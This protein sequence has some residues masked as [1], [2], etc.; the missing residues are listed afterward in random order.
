MPNNPCAD[1]Q[2]P[3]SASQAKACRKPRDMRRWHEGGQQY[4][5]WQ[6]RATALVTI[7][8]I[9]DPRTREFLHNFPLDHSEPASRRSRCRVLGNSWH[10]PTCRFLFTLLALHQALQ[11]TAIE[12]TQ[13]YP[14][15]SCPRFE[16]R[17]HPDGSRPILRARSCAK[18]QWDPNEPLGV[19]LKGPDDSAEQHARWALALTWEDVFPLGLNPSAS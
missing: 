2:R 14:P 5:P 13:W 4:P 10:L 6:Y 1:R 16:A 19:D 7:Q 8:G 17:F 9:P 3:F 12:G 11:V 15:V 18:M